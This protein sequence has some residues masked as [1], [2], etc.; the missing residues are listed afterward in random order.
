MHITFILRKTQHQILIRMP[1]KK[2]TE[3]SRIIFKG[4]ILKIIKNKDSQVVEFEFL[5]YFR[6]LLYVFNLY[7][8]KGKGSY[9]LFFKS[10]LISGVKFLIP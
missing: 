2:M 7:E 6:K 10:S 9:L 3:I 8:I 4:N 1:I 5:M